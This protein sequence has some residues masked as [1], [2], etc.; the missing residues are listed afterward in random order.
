MATNNFVGQVR[1]LVELMVATGDKPGAEKI[2]DQALAVVDDD[3]VQSAVADAE[4]KLR[5]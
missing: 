3:R 2:R 5:Q 1:K 4:Q